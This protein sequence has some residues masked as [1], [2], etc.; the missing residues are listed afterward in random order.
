MHSNDIKTVNYGA[1]PNLLCPRCGANN[2]HH[3]ETVFY[4][5]PEDAEKVT[6]II[7]D[8]GNVHVQHG[9]PNTGNPSTRRDGMTIR[10]RCEQCQD[11]VWLTIAQHKGSTEIGWHFE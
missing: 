9:M 6:R 3:G 1:V 5:R 4:E 10:F 7:V 8:E 2:L 11:P